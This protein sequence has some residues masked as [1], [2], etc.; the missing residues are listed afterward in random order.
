M[1]M[2]QL[3]TFAGGVAGG[4]LAGGD[5]KRKDTIVGLDKD[6]F[7]LAKERDAREGKSFDELSAWVREWTRGGT[8][9]AQGAPT[10]GVPG[11][12]GGVEEADQLARTSPPAAPPEAFSAMIGEGR[13]RS[14]FTESYPTLAGSL[15]AGEPG[16]PTFSS[17]T[18]L[19]SGALRRLPFA[20]K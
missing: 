2:R 10:G 17:V 8:M 12:M 1:K 7:A 9:T 19:S 3:S 11:S 18:R 14:G 20:L 13:M 15:L 6:R 16:Q 5:A 4:Y